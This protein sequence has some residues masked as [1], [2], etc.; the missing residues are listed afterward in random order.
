MSP[1]ELRIELE[2]LDQE[3]ARVEARLRRTVDPGRC[4]ALERQLAAL[5]DERAT[6]AVDLAAEEMRAMRDSPH[7]PEAIV[8]RRT[9][10]VFGALLGRGGQDFHSN[11]R[12]S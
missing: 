10:P 6:V 1:R 11:R 5:R 2:Q 12:A 8:P 7:P 9:L 4:A 3:V